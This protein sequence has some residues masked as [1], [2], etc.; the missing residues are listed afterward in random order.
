[1]NQKQKIT[2]FLW[3]DHQAEE[4][5]N[6]YCS[7]FNNSK[8]EHIARNGDHVMVAGFS[9]DGQKFSALN[10]GPMFR[11]DPSVSFFVV[12]ETEA[13]TES[14][15]EKLIEGGVVMMPLDWYNWSE[16]YGFLKDR[17]GLCWQISLEKN[18]AAGDK[19]RPTLLFSGPQKGRGEAAVQ[20]YTS[21]FE[22]SSIED[23][24]FYEEGDPGPIGTVKH[25]QFQLAGQ[26][27]KIMDNP[28]DQ[29]FTFNEALSFVVNCSDQAEVDFFWN[30][31]TA[32]GGAE[33]RCGWL[34]D[35]FGLSWQIIPEALPRLLSDPDPVVAQKAMAA[36]LQMNK[37]EIDKLS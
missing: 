27:F 30:K 19:F 10:G 8:I 22:D 21:L 11:F 36:M 25:A 18:G 17:Y 28:T 32:D 31:L 12:C 14:I 20:F 26:T 37:I 16:K 6:F 34:K 5:A 24:S 15:W 29:A 33:S 9:L 23:I 7:V 1:M 13:E 4:A 35:K 2:P 3:F